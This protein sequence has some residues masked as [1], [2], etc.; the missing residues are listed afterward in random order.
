MV[1]MMFS[2]FSQNLDPEEGHF[3]SKRFLGQIERKIN[4]FKCKTQFSRKIKFFQFER[5][6][7]KI[8]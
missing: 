8:N 5:M 4:F 6:D 3:W 7:I 2:N 1:H